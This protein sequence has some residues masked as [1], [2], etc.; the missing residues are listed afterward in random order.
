MKQKQKQ[1]IRQAVAAL[2]KYIYIYI[3]IYSARK[4]LTAKHSGPDIVC[5]NY[6]TELITN[7]ILTNQV[8]F[9]LD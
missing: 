2:Q 4:T 6:T 1:N 3:Y 9:R 8:K 7:I 5:L